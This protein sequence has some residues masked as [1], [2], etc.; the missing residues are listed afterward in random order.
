MKNINNL[1]IAYRC[2]QNQVSGNIQMNNFF[3]KKKRRHISDT[4]K[5]ST[6]ASAHYKQGIA[7]AFS[8]VFKN[9]GF[10][11]NRIKKA[12]KCEHVMFTLDMQRFI[13]EHY[14]FSV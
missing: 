1:Y 10:S 3:F 9:E 6:K 4:H 14:L 2:Y 5:K 11:G 12:I 8:N 7:K 13:E